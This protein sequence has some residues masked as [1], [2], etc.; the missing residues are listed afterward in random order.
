[1]AVDV[2]KRQK[3]ETQ[4]TRPATEG[5]AART[6]AVATGLLAGAA[7]GGLVCAPLAGIAG[8]AVGLLFGPLGAI[9]GAILGAWVGFEG[10][11]MV[12]GAVGGSKVAATTASSRFEARLLRSVRSGSERLVVTLVVGFAVLAALLCFLLPKLR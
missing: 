4:T 2:D 8:A 10:G 12:G 6:G 1:M 11:M 5:Q 7:L 9:L 3:R